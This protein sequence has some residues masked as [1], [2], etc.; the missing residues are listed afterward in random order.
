MRRSYANRHAVAAIPGFILCN[1]VKSKR[2]YA[3]ELESSA[4]VVSCTVRH[5][6]CELLT[7]IERLEV[8]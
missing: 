7:A 3:G 8:E 4:R 6:Q 2:C 1:C 5:F